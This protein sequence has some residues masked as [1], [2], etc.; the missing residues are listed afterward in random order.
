MAAGLAW[1]Y[2]LACLKKNPQLKL[3]EF[4]AER[5]AIITPHRA[6]IATIRN[7]LGALASTDIAAV[8]DTVDRIQGQER[9]LII[10]SYTVSDPDFI[11]AEEGFIL[12]PKR[13]NVSLTRAREKFVLLVSKSLLEYLPNDMEVAID[14]AHLQLFVTEYCTKL[15][16]LNLSW[17]RDNQLVAVNCKLRTRP[18]IDVAPADQKNP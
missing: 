14:S 13:F 7:L 9:D 6:Q 4:W 12:D 3:T 8:V 16:E 17:N 2:Y 1:A 18:V 15:A 11:A 5:L 10:A